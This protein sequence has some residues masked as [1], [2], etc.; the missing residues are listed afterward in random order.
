LNTLLP[1]Y[2]EA[3]LALSPAEMSDPRTAPSLL[4]ERAG[5]SQPDIEM[6]YAPFDHVNERA[7][8]VIVGLTP[9]RQ[10]AANALAAAKTALE[11]GASTDEA[12]AK[13][14]VFASFSGPMRANLVRLLD[15]VGV[16]RLLGI[17]TTADL[18]GQS[19]RLA[20]FTSAIR[21]PVFVN[22]ENWS[23]Q[24]DM[25][26]VPSMRVWLEK[27]T[28]EELTALPGALLV[29]LGPKVASALEHLASRGTIK[30]RMILRG[31]PHPSGAN[32]ERIACFLGEKPSHLASPK[33]N[34]AALIEAR[35]RLREQVAELG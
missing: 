28:G 13:A 14:K 6:I 11:A 18:W 10:Q 27:Y 31:L 15:C 34:G 21:Y 22:G 20:H 26:R 19:S 5:G 35:E 1:K 30:S 24:P 2:R 16:A 17:S 9:G 32:A 7:Q 12:A 8:I 25:L 3:V 29:P 23:G 33:T 4:I